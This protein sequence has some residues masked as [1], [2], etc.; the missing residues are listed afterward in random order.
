MRRSTFLSSELYSV[1]FLIRVSD[2]VACTNGKF[3]VFTMEA[4]LFLFAHL[5]KANEVT[6]KTVKI[7]VK[8]MILIANV[9]SDEVSTEQ[10]APC[11]FVVKN[12]PLII[13]SNNDHDQNMFHYQDIVAMNN[14]LFYMN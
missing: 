5:R 2:W 6:A 11:P 8:I 12:V 1:S 14:S 13:S 7:V 9:V 10:S 3:L 4:A